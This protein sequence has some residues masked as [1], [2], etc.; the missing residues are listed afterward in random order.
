MR[1]PSLLV[2]TVTLVLVLPSA[3]RCQLSFSDSSRLRNPDFVERCVRDIPDTLLIAAFNPHYPGFEA[4]ARLM[5]RM[6]SQRAYRAWGEYWSRKNQPHYVSQPHRLLIDTEMLTDFDSFRRYV[7]ED[8]EERDS[9]L[10]RADMVIRHRIRTWGDR[11]EQFG[12]RVDFNRSLGQ[13]GAYGFHYWFWARPLT[14]AYLLT[15]DQKYLVAFDELFRQWYEQRNSISRGFPELDV[16]Y[17]ELGLGVRNRLFIEY[18]L[19]PYARRSASTHE[20]MLKTVLGAAR[21]L[22]E[23][24]RWEGYRPGNWQTHGC[25][26]LIQIALVFPEFRE[27]TEWLRVG[28]ERMSAHLERDFFDDGGHCERSPRNYTQATYLTYRNLYYLLNAYGAGKDLSAE[29]KRSLGKT[30]DWWVTMLTP[31]GEVPAINDSHRGL[32]PVSILKDGAD[33]FGKR[34]ALGVMKRLLGPGARQDTVLPSFVSRNMASSGFAVMRTGW[35]PDALYMNIN[36]GPYGGP[37]T[38]NDLLDFEIYAYGQALAVDAGIGLTYD[39]PLYVP[40]YKSSPAHNMIV[41]NGVNMRREGVRGEDVVW[42]TTASLDYFAATS[43]GYDTLGVLQRRRIAFV[44]PDYW[45]VSDDVRA[46]RSSDTLRWYFHSPAELKSV[47]GGFASTKGPGVV[48]LSADRAVGFNWGK[49]L[50]ASTTVRIAGRTEEI[51]WVSLQQTTGTDSLY[52]FGVLVLPFRTTSPR[53]L[54]EKIARGRYR[55]VQGEWTDHL[56]FAGGGDRDE[57][58]D[59][60]GEF[61]WVRLSRG[62]VVRCAVVNG[63]YLLFGGRRIWQSTERCSWEGVPL[64]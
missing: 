21:W 22:Y 49:S 44:K 1:F 12:P 30:I 62:E 9:V 28:L 23:L 58:F 47:D 19:L 6:G 16:V 15:S 46:R 59:T 56:L 25:Y 51:S 35:T 2:G 52:T 4:T 7:K 5:R 3:A 34:E 24:E 42:S 27:S 53:P 17:Y 54:V 18:Y 13:S 64:R 61:V 48:V 37:H 57:N 60:D 50:A 38:H 29:V 63:T 14:M 8:P 43:R 32:F 20:K 31:T 40:W 33:F 55:V 45:F 36:Y 41:V 26:M 11:V 39:D 10:L